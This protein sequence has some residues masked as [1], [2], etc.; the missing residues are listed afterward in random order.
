MFLTF[1]LLQEEVLG[2]LLTPLGLQVPEILKA[3]KSSGG[4]KSTTATSFADKMMKRDKPYVSCIPF[5]QNNV[6]S[7][8][9]LERDKNEIKLRI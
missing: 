8:S 5:W 7:R 6:L 4:R 3:A 2:T 1:V 9:K